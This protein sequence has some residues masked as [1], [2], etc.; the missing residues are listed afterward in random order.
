MFICKKCNY[1]TSNKS[2]YNKHLKSKKHNKNSNTSTHKEDISQISQKS[3]KKH[4]YLKKFICEYCDKNF[5]RIDSLHRHQKKCEMT[6]KIDDK[7]KKIHDLEIKM[8]NE[9]INSLE[10]QL[11]YQRELTLSAGTIAN[12]AIT[13]QNQTLKFLNTYFSNAPALEGF[14]KSFMV[15]YAL[16]CIN[17]KSFEE[18]NDEYNYFNDFNEESDEIKEKIG[19]FLISLFI[20]KLFINEMSELI[21]KYY[22]KE[23]E[24]EQSIWSTDCSRK[25]FYIRVKKI[26]KNKENKEIK[27]SGTEV[28]MYDPSGE[29]VRNI[30]I[31][32]LLDCVDIYIIAYQ[33]ILIKINMEH[34]YSLPAQKIIDNL[35]IIQ[36]IA[37]FS[38]EIH[39]KIIEKELLKNIAPKL[40]LKI[41]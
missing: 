41:V 17:D 9:K 36:K 32:P 8:K 26:I 12:K 31:R 25:N 38:L 30:I 14:D 2:N 34:S 19:S 29:N 18:E 20:N 40:H 15:N 16:N 10:E 13:S 5:S 3:T 24:E 1:K 27:L 33:Q 28:W 21:I 39:D 22:K 11:K 6:K 4:M 7:D 23:D 37:Q 35:E